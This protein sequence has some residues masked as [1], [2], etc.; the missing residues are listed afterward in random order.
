MNDQSSPKRRLKYH[1]FVVIC[2]AFFAFFMTAQVS[3][4]EFYRLP[5]LEDEVTYVFQARIFARGHLVID[6]PEPRKAY[7]QPFVVDYRE[8]DQEPSKRFGKY[9]P[10]WPLLLSL[11][12]NLGQMWV[13]NAFCGMLA[14]ALAY[15]LGREIFDP[16]VGLIAAALLAFSPM[17]LLQNGALMGHPSAL[18]FFTL[19]MVAYWRMEKTTRTGKKRPALLWGVLAG[20]S[21]GIVVINR[22]LTA[23]GV[24]IPFILWSLVK[25]F[26]ASWDWR[27]GEINPFHDDH[28]LFNTVRPFFVIAVVTVIIGLVWP[29]Y[30][31]AAT[32]NPRQNLYTLVWSYDQVGFGECC[33]RHGHT[34]VKGIRQTRFDLSLMA[35]DLFGWQID[36]SPLEIGGVA[37]LP[38]SPGIITEDLQEHLRVESDYWPL[39]GLSFFILPFGLWL[40]FKRRRLRVWLLIGLAWLIIPLAL[41][42]DFLKGRSLGNNDFDGA[43]I[44]G[45]LAFGLVWM[46]IPPFIFAR[47]RKQKNVISSTWTWLLLGVIVGLIGTHLAYWIGSQRY[48][49]RYYYEALSALA[50]ISAL[51]IA[52]LAR[53]TGRLIVYPVFA[54]VLLWSLYGYSIP[55]ITALRDFNFIS[56]DILEEIE[57]RRIVDAPVLVIVTNAPDELA[58]W[59]AF[60]ALMAVTD[61]YLDSDI[62]VAWDYAPGSGV[63]EQILADFPHRQVIEMQAAGNES[64]FVE[65]NCAAFDPESDATGDCAVDVGP[66]D[67][68]AVPLP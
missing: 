41:D 48:S 68:F 33:G 28:P 12:V 50:I 39:T 17:A 57:A 25:I 3:R 24:T 27:N 32:G 61:P 34:I 4:T 1:P 43:K 67:S 65:G 59:R 6:T 29:I 52:W 7:W 54:A 53:R 21:L 36:S 35:A 64:W 14:V 26:A 42:M 18:C 62:V 13:I 20:I 56:A 45:W 66:E 49:T 10:G 8:N 5:H 15:R 23:I 47:I 51:P 11:G 58:R 31:W 44:W 19:F 55:R 40:G 30:N 38:F 46:L 9:S 16:D 60:G 2:L 63:R 37:L 22:P